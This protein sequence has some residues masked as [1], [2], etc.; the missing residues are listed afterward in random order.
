MSRISQ[1]VDQI[2]PSA[3]ILVSMKAMELKAQGRD[4]IEF[5]TDQRVVI[6]RWDRQ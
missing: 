5:F 1:K 6:S 2:K 3:T 4:A